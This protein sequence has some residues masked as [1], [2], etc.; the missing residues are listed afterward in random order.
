MRKIIMPEPEFRE[1]LEYAQLKP[2]TPLFV[3]IPTNQVVNTHLLT[4]KT[5]RT[6]TSRTLSK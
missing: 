5:C 6:S 3:S 4:T 1:R 2:A